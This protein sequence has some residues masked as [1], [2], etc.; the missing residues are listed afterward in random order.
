MLGIEIDH[1]AEHQQRLVGV[2]GA[3]EAVR[4]ILEH[5]HGVADQLKLFVH[6][7]EPHLHV[8]LRWIELQNL[9]VDCDRLQKEALLGIVTR[10]VFV[11]LDRRAAVALAHVQVADLEQGTNVPLVSIDQLLVLG[12]RLVV[13]AARLVL[14][15]RV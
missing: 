3:H 12:D 1:F 10:N 7:A 11:G 9:F 4:D 13:L 2:T 8:E 6:F 5:A 15:C 14:P